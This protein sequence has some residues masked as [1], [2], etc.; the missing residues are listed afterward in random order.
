MWLQI[1][2]LLRPP[3]HSASV[4][5]IGSLAEVAGALSHHPQSFL[6]PASRS[7]WTVSPQ[8][9]WETNCACA[10]GPAIHSHLGAVLPPLLALASQAERQSVAAEAATGAIRQ[11]SAA[12]A[13][14]G[15]YLL[16]AQVRQCVVGFSVR[17]VIT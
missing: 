5:A 10:A 2:K 17:R 9:A 7:C 8:C 16:I 12:V 14:D 13:E 4:R 15:A 3:L 1:P 6:W 11:V